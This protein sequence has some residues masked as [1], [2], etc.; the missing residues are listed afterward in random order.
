MSVPAKRIHM[1]SVPLNM[2]IKEGEESNEV[3]FISLFRSIRKHWIWQDSVKLK[4]WIDILLEVNHKPKKVL[5]GS[6]LID[7]N[8][9]QSVNS[10]QTWAIRWRTNVSAVRRFFALLES[11][12]MIVT[13]NVSKTTRIT[14]CKYE[15]YQDWRHDSETKVKRLRNDDEKIPATNNNANKENNDISSTPKKNFLFSHNGFFDRQIEANAGQPELDKYQKLVEFLHTKDE[16]G[17]YR[18]SNILAL[19]KQISYKDYITL[20]ETEK[21]FQNRPL[22]EVLEAMENTEGLRKKYKNVFLTANAWLKN[23][24]S[25]KK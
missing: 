11:D 5:L 24:F 1:H 4:W 20:K 8:R 13:E 17:E 21:K 15:S 3:G 2:P 9:G 12:N 14:V 18:F 6:R 25:D 23:D 22:K 16:E 10:L 7:C 19:K